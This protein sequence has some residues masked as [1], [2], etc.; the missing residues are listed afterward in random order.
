MEGTA[1]A[2]DKVHCITALVQDKL[3]VTLKY[4]TSQHATFEMWYFVGL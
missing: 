3:L 1:V 4:C 2:V